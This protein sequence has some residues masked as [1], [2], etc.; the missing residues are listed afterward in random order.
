MIVD[1]FALWFLVIIWMNIFDGFYS[2]LRKQVKEDTEDEE[3]MLME[4]KLDAVRKLKEKIRTEQE[5]E[6]QKLRLV[7]I[8]HK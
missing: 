8:K 4:G 2:D 7:S 3:A 1:I 6:E 5:E